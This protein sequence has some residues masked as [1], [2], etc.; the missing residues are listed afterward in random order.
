MKHIGLRQDSHKF[1]LTAFCLS[2][3][4]YTSVNLM[5]VCMTFS[6]CLIAEQVEVRFSDRYHH[7]KEFQKSPDYRPYWDKC[8][9]AVRD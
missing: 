3:T 4:I 8:M 5:G 9:E 7:F 2:N 1:F 6:V